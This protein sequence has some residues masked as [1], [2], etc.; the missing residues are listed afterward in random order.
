MLAAAAVLGVGS[1]TVVDP[2]PAQ[3]AAKRQVVWVDV[4]VNQAWPVS[5]AVAFVDKYTGSVMRFGK[6]RAGA[7][8]IVI[9]E[10]WHLPSL[11]AGVTYPGS[12]RA[13]I[14]LNP[15]RRKISWAQRYDTIVHELGHASG[16][17]THNSSCSS[18][19]YFAVTCPNGHV[20]SVAFSKGE[21][22]TLRRH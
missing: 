5:R 12:P 13:T 19:M 21:K 1:I 14:K 6:C 11:W 20:P 3:A 8:C 22:A 4:K 2:A 7:R 10:D 17:Y 9:R 15:T 16:V 18:V